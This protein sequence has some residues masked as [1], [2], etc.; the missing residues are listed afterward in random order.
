MQPTS[1]HLI[2]SNK[3]HA[4]FGYPRID[5]NQTETE[6]IPLV[7]TVL[8]DNIYEFDSFIQLWLELSPRKCNVISSQIYPPYG[9]L[10]H[11]AVGERSWNM[12]QANSFTFSL[13]NTNQGFQLFHH[14]PSKP[15]DPYS[16]HGLKM[17]A[18]IE[19]RIISDYIL[20]TLSTHD[21]FKKLVDRM[22]PNIE[23]LK[24][25]FPQDYDFWSRLGPEVG[26]EK[27]ES[28]DCSHL[29]MERSV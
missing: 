10:V 2:I 4:C 20:D 29:R 9:Q 17:L 14:P 13:I 28:Q 19:A 25:S 24:R 23:Y 6:G 12:L 22:A 7:Q 27:C 5:P 1:R 3:G 16:Q 21:D 18:S 8:D 26:P 11:K 15:S